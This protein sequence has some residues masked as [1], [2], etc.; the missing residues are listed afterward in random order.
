MTLPFEESEE[1]PKR[2]LLWR[3][4]HVLGSWYLTMVIVSRHWLECKGKMIFFWTVKKTASV[5]S[6]EALYAGGIRSAESIR[7]L[8]G[9][10]SDCIVPYKHYGADIIKDVIDEVR[11]G[12][13]WNRGSSLWRTDEAL[14]MVDGPK[15]G[16]YRRADEIDAAPS[17][18]FI[19]MRPEG[20]TI[21]DTFLLKIQNMRRVHL[22]QM[23]R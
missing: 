7:K 19:I 9:E 8:H 1:I 20:W 5:R 22:L 2:L 15:Q 10:L 6:A 4:D 14:E 12:W 16:K 21:Q 11:T 23:Q 13:S 3:V 18:G 17:P